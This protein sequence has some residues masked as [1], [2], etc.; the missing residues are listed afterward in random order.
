[1]QTTHLNDKQPL[2]TSESE[3]AV[4]LEDASGD[5]TGKGGGEDVARVQNSD[6]GCDFGPSVKVGDDEE[7][8]W[9]WDQPS[10]SLTLTV[11]GLD[12]TEEEASDEETGKILRKGRTDR[13]GGP[14][15]HDAAQEETWLDAGDE[16]VGGDTKDDVAGKEDRDAGLVLDIG[17]VEVLDEGG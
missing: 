11:R 8:S 2:P 12:N 1:M 4:E 14:S 17:H 7:G 16:H 13:D 5:E 6:T 15:H 9:V 10:Y 3:L